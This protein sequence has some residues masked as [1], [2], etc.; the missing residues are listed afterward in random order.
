MALVSR[1]PSSLQPVEKDITDAGG[2]A[3]SF[4]TDAGM[5]I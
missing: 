1:S 4:A 3:V 5:L 2:H